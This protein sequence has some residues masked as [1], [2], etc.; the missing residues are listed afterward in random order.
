M[1]YF[2][3]CWESRRNSEPY[4]EPSQTSMMKLSGKNS[5]G[6][7]VDVGLGSKHA[8]VTLVLFKKI[9]KNISIQFMNQLIL[10]HPEGNL[11]FFQL[12][13][14]IVLKESV[15]NFSLSASM[16]QISGSKRLHMWQT[17]KSDFLLHISWIF[18]YLDF[19]SQAF[20]IHRTA[21]KMGGYFFNFSLL[22]PTASLTLTHQPGD[23]CRELHSAHRQHP[24]PSWE[25]LVSE[26]KSLT[27]KLPALVFVS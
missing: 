14:N 19:L 3:H 23:Y 4:F 5:Q 15:T 9:C 20:T 16:K 26:S 1:S 21:G 11:L 27:T 12:N 6:S 25:P 24:N 7:I 13:R 18:F 8:S 17:K 2:Q 22:L 10:V